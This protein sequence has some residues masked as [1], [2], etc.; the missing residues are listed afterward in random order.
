[1]YYKNITS[2]T[3]QD[4]YVAAYGPKDTIY[5]VDAKA[6]RIVDSSHSCIQHI[7][8]GARLIGL[9]SFSLY[10]CK[11]GVLIA[12]LIKD[13]EHP[14]RRYMAKRYYYINYEEEE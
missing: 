5:I 1:M 14:R 12:A 9:K 4:L 10:F 2:L 11:N 6:G 8:I 13:T 3:E 7:T